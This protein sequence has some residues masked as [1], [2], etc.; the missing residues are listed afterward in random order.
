MR[1]S[2]TGSAADVRRPSRRGLLAGVAASA[3]SAGSPARAAARPNILFIMADDL[4]YADLSCYGR[5]DYQTPHI[6][7]LAAEGLLLTQAYANSPVCSATRAALITGRYQYRLPVG[8]YEPIRSP[9]QGAGLPAGFP[10]LPEQ[11]RRAGYRTSLIGKWHLGE[12]PAHGPLRAGYQRFF[13]VPGGAS[14]YFTHLAEPQGPANAF[15]GLWEGDARADRPGYL[16]DLL[17]DRAVAEIGEYARGGPPFFIS[18]HFTAPHWPWEGPAEE[19][20]SRALTRLQHLEGGSLATYAAM[21]GSLDDNVGKVL[22]AL[23]RGGLSRNTLVVFTSDN[24]GERFSDVW[25]LVGGKGEL[26]EGGI[27]VPA[28]VRW[29]GEIGPGRRSDQTAITMDWLPT[30]LAAAGATPDPA[31]ASDGEDLLP[32]LRGGTA[33]RPRKLFWRFNTADQAAVRDGDW[34]YLKLGGKEALFDLAS[35]V[36]ERA[37]LKEVRPELFERLKGEFAAWN[38]GMLP[39][40]PD[41]AGANAKTLFSDRY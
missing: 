29:P 15:D 7:R 40:G 10:T 16:T 23:D 8:L 35:D 36:R 21:V 25:P 31:F 27:R 19:A 12:I 24:G 1:R 5:R 32:I 2:P 34:K 38:A 11:L 14:D 26:L 17:G 37:N 39:Y 33:P 9:Q 4:G 22:A 13:G 20:V 41:T 18:L 6:D 28:L 30:L 3:V